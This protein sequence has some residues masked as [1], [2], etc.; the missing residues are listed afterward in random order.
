MLKIEK[1]RAISIFQ[2]ASAKDEKVDQL[3]KSGENLET[4]HKWHVSEKDN[5]INALVWKQNLGQTEHTHQ[6]LI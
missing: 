2:D 4:A 5:D 3:L 1:H 6:D